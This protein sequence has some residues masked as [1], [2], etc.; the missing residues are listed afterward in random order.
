[1]KVAFLGGAALLG[2]TSVPGLCQAQSVTNLSSDH[3][4]GP[5]AIDVTQ[6]D[7]RYKVTSKYKFPP[8]GSSGSKPVNQR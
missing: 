2:F 7:P 8:A 6:G 5:K 3:F 1:M 4:Y